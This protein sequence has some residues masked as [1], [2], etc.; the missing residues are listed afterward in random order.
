VTGAEN[1]LTPFD[2]NAFD[3]VIHGPARLGVV[4][5]LQVHGPLDF[6]T[7]KSRLGA[8][9][10]A[11]GGHL[12]KL[13]AA[14]YVRC[15]KSFVGRRPKSTYRITPAGRRALA[16]YLDGMQKVI[17]AVR[18]SETERAR[19]GDEPGPPR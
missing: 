12:L 4:A 14:G 10:G 7:L 15:A 8:S 5:A 11:L 18:R 16:A 1:P 3:P 19:S 17:E 9:D 2:A 13:E 6:T